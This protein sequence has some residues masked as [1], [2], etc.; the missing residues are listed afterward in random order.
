MTTQRF[1]HTFLLFTL[2][3]LVHPSYAQVKLPEE[4]QEAIDLSKKYPYDPIIATNAE[5][6]YKFYQSTNSEAGVRA[7][8]LSEETLMC[9][10]EGYVLGKYVSTDT[11]SVIKQAKYYSGKGLKSSRTLE[12]LDCVSNFSMDIFDTDQELC[13]YQ[14]HFDE[15]GDLQKYAITKEYD[16]LKF[17]TKAFV[18]EY[19]PVQ[20][21]TL[22][23]EVPTWLE[24]EF[25]ELN[26][27]GI[28]FERSEQPTNV[29]VKRIT[30]EF[31]DL[32]ESF[33]PS[34]AP[35]KTYY[36][37][38]IVLVFKSYKKGTQIPLM[39]T[40]ADQYKWY[41][42]LVNEVEVI[43]DDLRP[44]VEKILI[45]KQ[46]EQEKIEAI[47]YWVQDNIRYIAFERGVMGFRP[48]PAHKVCS[49][50]FGDCKG[51][52]NLTKSMLRLAGFDA[53]LTW[54]GTNYISPEFNY[55]FP[56]LA[57]DN[58]MICALF[59]NDKKYYLD[60]TESYCAFGEYA[61]RIQGRK[62]LIEDGENYIIETVP[63]AESSV[64]KSISSADISYQN[65][66]LHGKAS[67]EY[68]GEEKRFVLRQ[69]QNLR[70]NLKDDAVKGF[71]QFDLPEMMIGTYTAS[72][73]GDRSGDLTFNYEFDFNHHTLKT[74][75]EVYVNLEYQN[76]FKS[77]FIDST[78]TVPI[79]IGHSRYIS[80][81][82][83]FTIPAGYKVSHLPEGFTF[84]EDGLDIKIALK[85]EAGKVVYSKELTVDY[86]LISPEMIPVWNSAMTGLEKMYN[87][88]I[89]LQKL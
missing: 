48:E 13:S 18:L 50:R 15:I 64:N 75:D 44:L 82:V 70:T 69:Y 36:E 28:K 89:I 7:S 43:D 47:F 35:G 53:R 68:G 21:K 1:V 63:V 51:M 88:Y 26:F 19:H 81:T 71:L 40:I 55:S 62:V 17:L 31:T 25:I 8:E 80:S 33:A 76:Y 2:L 29:G 67:V 56:S 61:T 52:A 60:G 9:L 3:L 73:L 57:N 27:D 74:E 49:K 24:M 10:R 34:G 77:Y 46:T 42:E 54:I 78:R 16:D 23:F 12:A 37:P 32:P 86:R 11:H 58:H 84:S 72:D 59:W 4:L 45:G 20:K 14:L 22:T 6:T 65:G 85:E 30:Y 41:K 66:E 87:H 83:N 5:V 79:D 39:A 38:Q